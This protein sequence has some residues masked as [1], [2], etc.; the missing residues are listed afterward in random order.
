MENDCLRD[1]YV[2][3]AGITVA[4]FSD[5]DVLKNLRADPEEIWKRL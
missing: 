4:G 1:A 3:G 5:R 2:T